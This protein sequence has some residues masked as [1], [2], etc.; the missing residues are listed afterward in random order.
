MKKTY[1]LP[2]YQTL[3]DPLTKSEKGLTEEKNNKK[4]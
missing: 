3:I 1:E 4:E 2:I